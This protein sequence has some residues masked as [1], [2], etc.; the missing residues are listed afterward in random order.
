M[1][2]Q[3]SLRS[4]LY[5]PANNA[6]AVEKVIVSA[7]AL[8]ADA[9]VFDLEDA[10]AP[11]Q[12]RTARETLRNVLKT[13]RPACRILIR[14]NALDSE[15]GTEDFLAALAMSPDAIVLP[16]VESAGDVDAAL[17]A[18]EAS[19]AA[20][21]LRLWAMI[22]SP[23]AVLNLAQIA[24]RAEADNGRLEALMLGTNDL[25][26]ATGVPLA[27][28]RAAYLPWIMQCVAAARAY[29]LSIV[30]GVYTALENG[31][32]FEAE[33]L[34]GAQL[35][36]DGKSLIHPKQVSVCNAAFTPDAEA[37]AEAKAICAAFDDPA[38]AGIAVLTVENKMVEFLHLKAAR[39]T[40]SKAGILTKYSPIGE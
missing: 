40:L 27:A 17:S 16:K 31:P 6:R 26:L 11:G 3:T 4:V 34:Q 29:G 32:E 15:W 33:C 35:G 1:T 14:I 19:D 28:G 22:E 7:S 12:K 2:D 23:M 37:I 18:C 9:V 39:R 8:D 24:S 30:D 10:V 21:S 38:N 20:S 5:V 13:K 25:S 36:L